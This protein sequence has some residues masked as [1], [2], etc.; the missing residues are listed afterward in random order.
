MPADSGDERGLHRRPNSPFW[1]ICYSG[2]DGQL[3]RESTKVKSK[4][5]AR[6]ILNER[7]ASVAKGEFLGLKKPSKMTLRDLLYTKYLHWGKSAKAASSYRRDTFSAIRLCEHLGNQKLRDISLEKIETYR[8]RRIDDGVKQATVNREIAL[9][10][11]SLSKAI[12][13]GLLSGSNPAAKVRAFKEKSRTRYLNSEEQPRLLLACEQSR[14]K[15]LL[16][17]VKIAL[18][19]GLRL[20]ELHGLEW[21]DLDYELRVLTVRDGKGGTSRVIP[22]NQEAI[23]TLQSI[24]R[25]GDRVFPDASYKHSFMTALRRAGITDFRLHDTRRSCAVSLLTEGADLI[26]IRD[27]LGHAEIPQTLI[28]L[29]SS[30]SRLRQAVDRLPKL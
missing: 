20:A 21:R 9:L 28:Y 2:P 8:Q 6:S 30:Q 16:P 12:Q 25:R 11:H 23:D 17:F 15:M 14:Q 19:T 5:L 18:L 26:T 4:K 24:E 29:A 22:L 3:I 1:W 27:F 7:R 10:R 13:W